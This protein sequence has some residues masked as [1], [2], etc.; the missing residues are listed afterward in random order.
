MTDG[1][2]LEGYIISSPCEPKGSGELK[3]KSAVQSVILD[4]KVLFVVKLD[5]PTMPTFLKYK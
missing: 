5:W 1:C 4:V 2:R 3:T